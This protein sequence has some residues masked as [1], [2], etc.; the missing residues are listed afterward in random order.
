MVTVQGE[1]P[2][3][4]RG[5]AMREA[6]DALKA[7]LARW[8]AHS[9]RHGAIVGCC[10]LVVGGGTT[11]ADDVVIPAPEVIDIAPEEE[12]DAPAPETAEISVD[13]T[14]QPWASEHDGTVDA[15]PPQV[16]S[17]P[18]DGGSRE[19]D[20]EPSAI[21]D[22]EPPIVNDVRA[23]APR[24]PAARVLELESRVVD[25][26]A[27]KRVPLPPV[28]PLAEK[29]P[30]AE[31]TYRA[32]AGLY[33]EPAL[34]VGAV[35]LG[36]VTAR[37]ERVGSVSLH[38]RLLATRT[39]HQ[40]HRLGLSVDQPFDLPVFARVSG[41]FFATNALPYCGSQA[42]ACSN[43][44]AYR[45][46]SS[47]GL[48]GNALSLALSRYH[49]ERVLSS[50]GA[51]DVGA[52]LFSGR[53]A[54]ELGF[55]WFGDVIVDGEL[56]DF[57][58]DRAPDLAPFPH[59]L[60]A[61]ESPDGARVFSH[62]PRATLAMRSIDDE[63]YPTRGFDLVVT[64]RATTRLLGASY[65][66]LAV[67][68]SLEGYVPLGRDSGFVLASRTLFDVGIGD[69]HPLDRARFQVGEGALGFGGIDVGRG[70]RLARHRGLVKVAEQ[71]ELRFE[72]I[73]DVLFDLPFRVGAAAFADVGYVAPDVGAI[74]LDPALVHMGFGA[75]A[76]VGLGPL[77]MRGDL[78][79]SP[80]E[81]FA[82]YPYLTVAHTF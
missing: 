38:A 31:L 82:P 70:I 32:G 10:A 66:L 44:D 65:N 19:F 73:V 46:L 39:L 26:K 7:L 35:L 76:R 62:G 67:A 53:F 14:E 64:P 72:S 81:N 40:D 63:S 56:G 9:A 51:V 36:N 27:K 2:Q 34:G 17:D 80:D 61:Q 74:R 3:G 50:S 37:R 48:E 54:A 69:A 41:R 22:E 5:N 4:A 55:G 47:S 1:A 33:F 45:A 21:V 68:G 57:D 20:E 71:A 52:P 6:P 23:R 75:G 25:A 8:R 59:S 60:R 42:R 11:L 15:G 77:V 58:G 29:E 28:P 30:Q 18:A 12:G 16:V 79:F 78:A 13:A 43:G 24:E 49:T